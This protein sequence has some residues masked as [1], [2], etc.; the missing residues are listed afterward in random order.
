MKN[1]A[2]SALNRH[3]VLLTQNGAWLPAIV[4]GPPAE[5][6]ISGNTQVPTNAPICVCFVL[7]RKGGGGGE[8]GMYF[9][10]RSSDPVVLPA[11]G[12]RAGLRCDQPD[13]VPRSELTE[14]QEQPVHDGEGAD[15]FR[16]GEVLVAAGHDV[17]EGGLQHEA[18]DQAPFRP[19]DVGEEGAE[20][21]AG[22]V[23]RGG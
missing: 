1:T 7:A 22:D 4:D 3:S 10:D 16:G 8:G 6:M 19:D 18:D 21:R 11:D 17:A 13:V 2:R 20:E 12:G 23:L 14:R 5:R 9:A 15:V